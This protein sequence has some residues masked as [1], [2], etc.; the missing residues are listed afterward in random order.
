MKKKAGEAK[1]KERIKKKN[2]IV[3]FVSKRNHPHQHQAICIP[4]DLLL[5]DPLECCVKS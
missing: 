1:S 5:P 3:R 4:I 2:Q